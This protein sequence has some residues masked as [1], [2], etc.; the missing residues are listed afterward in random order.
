MKIIFCDQDGVLIDRSYQTTHSV[1]RIKELISSKE[2]LLIPNSDTPLRRLRNNFESILTEKLDI[3][4]AERGAIVSFN[5]KETYTINIDSKEVENYK[6][7][8]IS[9]ACKFNMNVCIGD[10][11]SWIKDKKIFDPESI[12]LIVDGLRKTSVGYYARKM[13]GIDLINTDLEFYREFIAEAKKITLPSIFDELDYNEDYA[14]AI[15]S[16]SK[17]VKTIGINHVINILGNNH[18]YYMIGDSK[19]D[20]INNKQ[21]KILAVGNSKKE[22]LEVADFIAPSS[23]TQGMIEC[24]E[25]A[26]SQ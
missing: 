4:I 23:Y 8:I 7:G 18:Q 6:R 25:W 5:G 2:I 14:I 15:L 11:A 20:I 17:A 9:L 24:M 26:I 19:T 12:T 10:S 21:V 3:I 13:N 22:L 16:S 1:S